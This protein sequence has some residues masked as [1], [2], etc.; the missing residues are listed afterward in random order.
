MAQITIPAVLDNLETALHF[1]E[2]QMQSTQ[3]PPAFVNQVEL[4]VEEVFVNIARYAYQP[5][6][7]DVTMECLV[8]ES[9]HGVT[10]I[11]CDEGKPYNPLQRPDP[12]LHLGVEERP[13]G[14][15]GILM[16]KKLMDTVAYEF[17]DGKNC[18]TLKKHLAQK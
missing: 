15:L 11:F 3:C 12:D 1:V 10:V 4:A 17:R 14:G 8:T 18:L 13:I 16:V 7:G 2:T 9:P 6:Q 5:G